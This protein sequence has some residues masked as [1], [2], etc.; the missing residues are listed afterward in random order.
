MVNQNGELV[1]NRSMRVLKDGRL[2]LTKNYAEKHLSLSALKYGEK[3]EGYY[4]YQYGTTSSIVTFELPSLFNT[5]V[6]MIVLRGLV[7]YA[8]PYMVENNL[9]DRVTYQKYIENSQKKIV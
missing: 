4:Y 2:R 3:I 5:P 6:Y 7:T 1:F 8:E 9:D